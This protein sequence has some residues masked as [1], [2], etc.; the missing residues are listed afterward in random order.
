MSWNIAKEMAKINEDNLA[1]LSRKGLYEKLKDATYRTRR[2]SYRYKKAS[3]EQLA[4]IKT[5]LTQQN[6]Q[7]RRKRILL[8]SL[9]IGIMTI[10]IIAILT[11]NI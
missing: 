4:N 7:S 6:L 1:K 10:S 8:M 9:L 11:V 5:N 2:K 3:Q